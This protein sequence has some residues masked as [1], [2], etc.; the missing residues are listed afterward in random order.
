L[1]SV[2]LVTLGC[3]KNQVD[4]Q[5]MAALLEESGYL[6]TDDPA[7]ADVVIVNTCGFIAPAREESLAELKRLAAGKRPGQVLIAAGCLAEL[8]PAMLQA[9]VRRLDAVLGTRRW[10]DIADLLQ[11]LAERQVER[12]VWTGDSARPAPPLDRRPP[13]VTA[14]VKIADGCNA[15]CAFCSIPRIKGP[16]RSRPPEAVIAEVQR[17]AA[18]GYK[19]VILVAQDSTA[20]GRDLGEPDGLPELLRAIA[21]AAP[22]LPWLRLMYTYPQ[23]IS[24]R[25]LE[26]MAGT[27]MVCH[28]L[29]LPL[30]HAHPDVLRRM[31]RPSDPEAL[32]RLLERVRATMPDVALRTAFIV[33]FPGETEAEF[34]TLLGFVQDVRFDHVGVFTYSREPGTPAYEMEPQVP[35]AVKE[36][37]RSRLLE[38]QQRLSLQKNQALVGRRLQVLVEGSGDG[39]SVGR[40]YRDAPEVDGLAILRAEFPVGSLVPGRVVQGMEYDLL[41]DPLAKGP[42]TRPR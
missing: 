35:E 21:T 7:T 12:P 30:Q 20:Y 25:L 31:R 17:L 40:T 19:E 16:F 4:S 38:L 5:S 27:P 1:P 6:L 28:Y 8:D 32:L 42:G 33:G 9:R 22:A 15:P 23:H 2:A 18:S 13:G 41:L 39:I 34:E 14:Y 36:Q 26:A 24:E 10:H 37:R 11:A 29:D 3:P